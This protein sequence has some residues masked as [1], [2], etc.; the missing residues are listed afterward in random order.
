MAA[1]KRK[2]DKKVSKGIHGGGGKVRTLTPV[3]LALMGKGLA[4]SF[5]PVGTDPATR[6][7]KAEANQAIKA[8]AKV[9]A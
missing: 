9:A 4:Q 5:K 1:G 2:R 8:I 3:A 6:A 7:N